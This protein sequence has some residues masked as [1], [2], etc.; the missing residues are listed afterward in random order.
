[1]LQILSRDISVAE[2][3]MR[4]KQAASIRLTPEAKRLLALLAKQMGISQA[5]VIELAV[6]L[7]AKEEGIKLP[8]LE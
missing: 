8:D 2:H 6:R 4:K 5:A 1:M 7:M 3:D